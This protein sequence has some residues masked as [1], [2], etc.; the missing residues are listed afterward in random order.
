AV[1]P[2]MRPILWALALGACATAPPVPLTPQPAFRLGDDARP[3]RYQL[4]LQVD[5]AQRRVYGTITIDVELAHA[6]RVVW[7]NAGRRVLV[8]RA[9]WRRGDPILPATTPHTSDEFVG[10]VTEEP[11]AAGR[12]QLRLVFSSESSV[13]EADGFF[14]RKVEGR[15]YLFSHFE[16]L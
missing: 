6:A 2:S 12:A 14:R 15:S 13:R 16:P 4:T 1:Q 5:P 3:L 10:V 9:E 7:L 8:E 11:L